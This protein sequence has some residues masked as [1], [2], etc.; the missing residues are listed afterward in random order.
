M[1]TQTLEGLPNEL[2]GLV[3][4]SADT[5]AELF[6]FV[7]ASPQALRV[8]NKS[9]D[10]ILETIARRAIPP[11]NMPAALAV[12]VVP[13]PSA[14]YYFQRERW[15]SAGFLDNSPE[16]TYGYTTLFQSE[17][18]SIQ[19]SDVENVW[20]RLCKMAYLVERFI[21]D[22]SQHAFG[23]LSALRVAIC[24]HYQDDDGDM[25][26]RERDDPLTRP[27]TS[28]ERLRL[29]RAFFRFEGHR[30]E[31]M[32]SRP[33]L[34]RAK[35]WDILKPWEQYELA[36]IHGFLAKR[37]EAILENI[38]R[39]LMQKAKTLVSE[40]GEPWPPESWETFS[41]HDWLRARAGKSRQEQL[42][43]ADDKIE[44]VDMGTL[45]LGLFT[46]YP[47]NLKCQTSAIEY[48][49]A[50]GLPFDFYLSKLGPGRQL[51]LLNRCSYHPNGGFCFRIRKWMC[52]VASPIHD[53]NR[54]DDRLGEPNAAWLWAT[55]TGTSTTGTQ[56]P[57]AHIDHFE[58]HWSINALGL[59]FWD[60]PRLQ[61]AKLFKISGQD[62]KRG[63]IPIAQRY[64]RATL[65]TVL[66]CTKGLDRSRLSE[67]RAKEV[68]SEELQEILSQLEY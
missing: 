56:M 6:A 12:M 25:S 19:P 38:E 23:G 29:Q 18:D 9:R 62:N 14:S 2:I 59:V 27:L 50:F 41:S 21:D 42:S 17:Q 48:I 16:R 3:L 39:H 68:S 63:I 66:E 26:G 61:A 46:H 20:L 47:P 11:E 52:R 32:I 57:I 31:T 4:S 1:A 5:I 45:R 8:F 36:C 10:K 67:L 60:Q 65:Q 49:P 15:E 35:C 34:Y 53:S 37:S 64:G 22:F 13:S 40:S 54:Y 28:L 24:Q 58:Q 7:S 30:K 44:P 43:E 55:Q 33:T 51:A